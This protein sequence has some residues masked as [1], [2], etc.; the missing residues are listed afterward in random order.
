MGNPCQKAWPLYSSRMHFW[1]VSARTTLFP[2][3]FSIFSKCIFNHGICAHICDISIGPIINYK[4]ENNSGKWLPSHGYKTQTLCQIFP[5][6]AHERASEKACNGI[7]VIRRKFKFRFFF[8][9]DWKYSIPFEQR[10]RF[11]RIFPFQRTRKIIWKLKYHAVKMGH[12]SMRERTKNMK[13]STDRMFSGPICSGLLFSSDGV[14]YK[15]EK[16]TF[17]SASLKPD[18]WKMFRIYI[19]A[20]VKF[21]V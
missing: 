6:F 12:I 10:I 7:I 13:N 14:N 5:Q 21:S 17:R 3:I 9:K 18:V 4:W 20:E 11:G 8:A 19:L 16:K 15:I 2:L 1:D